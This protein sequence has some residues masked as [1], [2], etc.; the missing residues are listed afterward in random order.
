MQQ[1]ARSRPVSVAVWLTAAAGIVL[2]CVLVVT[3]RN[4]QQRAIDND[5][6]QRA[7]VRI[8]AVQRGLDDA[9]EVVR[10]LNQTFVSFAPVDRAR[11]RSFTAPLLQHYPSIYA[12]NFHR[13]LDGAQRAPYEAAL[14][15]DY[16]DFH[17]TEMVDGKIVAAR[18]K[19]AYIVVDYI[20]PMLQQRSAFGLDVSSNVRVVT[21]MQHAVDSGLPTASDLVRLAQGDGQRSG[22]LIVMPVFRPG[23]EINSVAGRRAAWIGDTAAVFNVHQLIHKIFERGGFLSDD[24]MRIGVY[25][26]ASDAP[27]ELVYQKTEAGSVTGLRQWTSFLYAAIP[28]PLERSFD[29]AG[30]TWRVVVTMPNGAAGNDYGAVV[31][32]V[33]GLVLS[34]GAAAYLNGVIART[35]RVQTLV[36]HRTAELRE[37]NRQLSD[38]ITARRHTEAALQ[39]RERAIE[40]CANAIMIASA[41]RPHYAI[42]YVNSAFTRITGRSAET[43][44]GRPL[45]VIDGTEHHDD[46]VSELLQA[47]RDRRQAHVVLHA[48]RADGSVFW[49]DVYI[50]PVRDTSGSVNH[51]VVAMYDITDNKRYEAE[52]EFQ[53]N[54]DA[55]TGLANRNL[56]HDR[57]H[58]AIAFA[59]R[60][61]HPIWLVFVD[62]DQFKFI[63][64]TLG[65]RAGDLMLKTVAERLLGAVRESDTV[66]RLGGDEFVLIMP[67]RT[68]GALTSAIIQRLMEAVAQPMT[69]EQHT[70]FVTA[71]IGVAVYPGD[72][73]E[74]DQLLKHADIAMY[75]AKESGRNNFQFYTPV[76]N[77][78]A[79]ER[80]QLEGAL[81]TAIE[82]DEFVLHYQPQVDLRSGQI[83]GMEALLRWQHPEMGM[84]PPGRFIALAEE[85]GMIVPIGAW[86][87]ATAC[88]QNKAW[89]DAGLGLLRMSVNLSARQFAQQDLV[90]SIAA[91]LQETGLDPTYLEVELTESLVM[92][93]VERA[94]ATLD[95]LHELGVFLSIDDFG[96]GYSSL[97]YLKRF[98]IDILKID[99]S[100]VRDISVDPDDAAIVVS[101]ISLAHSLRMGVIAEG[102]ETVEQLGFLR[103]YGCDQMQG[104]FFSRPVA[105]AAFEQLLR[106][107]INL[108]GKLD[109]HSATLPPLVEAR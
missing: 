47:L 7:S 107:G 78:R 2:T 58:H 52:L 100:F 61:A 63:N 45:T 27:S 60:N 106:D 20:E 93:D 62:L 68:D 1:R 99:Q 95:R 69:I 67:E 6:Q 76:M 33:A 83:V 50:A 79:L 41:E 34:L 18:E 84:V 56:L 102:V 31:V 109:A 98:P 25:F 75:R 57:L 19:S 64:D 92:T 94:I 39:L 13:V 3:I 38:D 59:N 21:A 36:D 89:Q 29:N 81:R 15:A 16:P 28:K 12:F 104:Y 103:R 96:T 108:Q 9:V 82:R 97:S 88:R 80:L 30:Q 90:D 65:H 10:V 77:E 71:S 55:L 85:T 23:A 105:A 73:M 86:V 24:R 46:T 72:G 70:F 26:A 43:V 49:S 42:E 51:F 14:Q 91:V 54:R 11:F 17:L 22:L 66:A 32:L 87:V 74:P 40:A 35:R 5:F 37:A 44:L 48:Y 4:L 8:A 101:I 53:A